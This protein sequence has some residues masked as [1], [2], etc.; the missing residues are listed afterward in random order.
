MIADN[1][2]K[3]ILAPAGPLRITHPWISLL[4]LYVLGFIFRFTLSL[5]IL[6]GPTVQIDE[7]LYINIAKSLAAGEGIAYRSQPVPYPYILY[8]LLLSPLYLFSLPFDLYRVVQ[9]YN[10]LLIATSVFPVF[11]FA[12]DYSG[13]HRKAFLASALT[14]LMPDMQMTG[15]QMAESL[16]WPLSLWLVFFAYRMFSLAERRL[17]NGILTGVFTALLFWTKPGTIAMGLVLLLAALTLGEK[18]DIRCRRVPA[19]SGFAACGGLIFLFYTLYVFVFGYDFSFLGLY[20]KQ[21]T[22][23]SAKWIAAVAEFSFLQLFLFAV[24]CGGIFFLFPYLC[25]KEYNKEQ[26]SFVLALSLGLVVTAFGTAAFVDMFQWNQ[27]FT[28]PQLHLRYMAMFVPVMVVFS[29]SAKWPGQAGRRPALLSLSVLAFLVLF[30]GPAVGFVNGI[31]TYIDSLSLSAWLGDIFIPSYM[32]SLLSGIFIIFLV[33]SILQVFRGKSALQRYSLIFLVFFLIYNGVCGYIACSVYSDSAGY[34]RDAVEMNSL[35]EP[36][37][38][39]VLIVTQQNYHDT[40]SYTLES[41]LRKPYQQATLDALIDALSETGGI[42]SPFIP[43]DQDPNVGNHPTPETDTFLFGITVADHVEFSSSA[44]V[45][46]S[47]NG[48]YSLVHVPEGSRIADTMLRG[49]DTQTLHENEPARLYVFDSSRYKNGKLTLHLLAYAEDGPVELEIH[50]AGQTQIFTITEKSK[51]TLVSLREGE[52][53]I[54]AH[55]GDV[56]IPTYW[57]E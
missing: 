35:L 20:R 14:L 37:S 51:Q 45:Q 28:N 7:S 3:R 24:S 1:L 18:S 46:K 23:L 52:T 43:E 4:V 29:L 5:I 38:E 17:L 42:Y 47:Q 9:F 2:S 31:S 21:L 50:N 26:K 16:I 54:T 34:G 41:R 6:Q 32:G 39:E 53:I 33:F 57:T 36:V 19:I 15:F 25:L 56:L 13:S 49:I 44:D 12:K 55:G 8:P 27:S 22:V 40:R 48:W 30:P 10:S 11:L